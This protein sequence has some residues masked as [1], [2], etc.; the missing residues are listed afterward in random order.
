[1][2]RAPRV[3]GIFAHPDDETLCAG[4]NCKAYTEYQEQGCCFHAHKIIKASGKC[5]ETG[6]VHAGDKQVH[7]VSAFIS[8]HA[9]KVHHM[10]H[11]GIFAG[12][13]HAA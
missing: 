6:N 7:F 2:G 8:D 5:V 10:A 12:N 4:T 3:L 9:F 1:M 11:Y 13:A